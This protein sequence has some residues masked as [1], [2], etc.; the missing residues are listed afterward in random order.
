MRYIL[1]VILTWITALLAPNAFVAMA[2]TPMNIKTIELVTAENYLPFTGKSLPAGGLATEL[3]DAAF[4]AVD[5]KVNVTWTAWKRAVS[6]TL[7]GQFVG[8]FPYMETPERLKDFI[9]SNP[10]YT[11]NSYFYVR[12]NSD[13]TAATDAALKGKR[14][15]RPIGYGMEPAIQKLI[16]SKILVVTTP[17][18]QEICFKLLKQKRVDVVVETEL[19]AENTIK[20]SIG[21]SAGIV[22]LSEPV[23]SI[24]LGLMTAKESPIGQKAVEKFNDGLKIIKANG[25]YDKIVRK[26]LELQRITK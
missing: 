3:V 6:K 24:S 4:W 19:I 16:D 8:T 14:L 10:I 20:K 17:Q 5:L 26:H 11:M 7:S 22:R 13:I 2:E 25:T 12:A 1:K 15:C 21:S 9:F 18:S 23:G